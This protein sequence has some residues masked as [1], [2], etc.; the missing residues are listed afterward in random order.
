MCTHPLLK[1]VFT[2]DGNGGLIQVGEVFFCYFPWKGDQRSNPRFLHTCWTYLE[3][4]LD[5]YIHFELT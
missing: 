4:V 3:I 1:E 2:S 5:S